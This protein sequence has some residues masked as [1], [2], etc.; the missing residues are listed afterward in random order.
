MVAGRRLG[1]TNATARWLL[2]DPNGRVVVCPN[3]EHRRHFLHEV[4]RIAGRDM[5]RYCDQRVVPASDVE[6]YHKVLRSIGA[7]EVAF[8]DAERVLQQLLGLPVEFAAF[9]ATLIPTPV[10]QQRPASGDWV[11][12]EYYYGAEGHRQITRGRPIRDNP[13]G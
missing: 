13:Q 1:K 8:D 11:D 12:G 10:P 3:M 5:A 4:E 2:E 7:R 6:R 9:N